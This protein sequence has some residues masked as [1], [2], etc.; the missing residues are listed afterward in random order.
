MFGNASGFSTLMKK[1]SHESW[2]S[3]SPCIGIKALA[4]SPEEDLPIAAEVINFSRLRALTHWG[5][6]N[7]FVK[8]WKQDMKLFIR[9][10]S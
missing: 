9:F 10:L 6:K 5:V 4:N 2:L 7:F 1:D 3:T 8:K